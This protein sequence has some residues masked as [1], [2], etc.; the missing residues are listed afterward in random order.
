MFIGGLNWETTDGKLLLLLSILVV[1]NYLDSY[2]YMKYHIQLLKKILSFKSIKKN[3][4]VNTFL[5][6]VRFLIALLCGIQ[7]HNALVVSLS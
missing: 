1:E 6:L 2:F 4:Y 7:Q 3:L 5:N